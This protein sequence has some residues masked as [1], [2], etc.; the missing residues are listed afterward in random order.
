LGV[1][2]G[3]IKNKRIK[4][5]LGGYSAIHFAFKQLKKVVLFNL[6][7]MIKI[8]VIFTRFTASTIIPK[9]YQL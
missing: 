8:K 2:V 7:F 6:L 9:Q 5:K 4:V 3:R 1:A